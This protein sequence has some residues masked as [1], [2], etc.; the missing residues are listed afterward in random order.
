MRADPH[1]PHPTRLAP[2]H[3]H[4][5]RILA[6]HDAA[7]AAGDAG[8]TDPV[9]GYWVFTSDALAASGRCCEQGCRHCP[10]VGA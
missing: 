9:T 8:Y 7:E 4:R 10:W 6:A 2:D 5:A 3:P 1:R